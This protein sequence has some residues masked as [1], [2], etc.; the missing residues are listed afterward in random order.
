MSSSTPSDPK[1]PDPV[2]SMWGADATVTPLYPAR[3][4]VRMVAFCMDYILILAAT[5]MLSTQLLYPL[6]HPGFLEAS[7][8]FLQEQ[9]ERESPPGFVEQMQEYLEFQ[10]QH[11]SASN[12]T[13]FLAAV[14]TWLYFA[15][16]ELLLAGTTLGKKIFKLSL[17]DLKTLSRPDAKTIILRNCLKT[18]SVI[19]P[20]LFIV[21]LVMVFTNRLRMAGH[22]R[23]SKTLVTY[24]T[25]L[26]PTTSL[27]RSME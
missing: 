27:S 2:E 23:I 15:L 8:E 13:A 4:G 10:Y 6:F 11:E 7:R 17:I 24:E 14:I 22:D 12:D 3:F 16:S 25:A 19:M 20:L 26:P 5:V 1:H 21:N 18:L 9:Q